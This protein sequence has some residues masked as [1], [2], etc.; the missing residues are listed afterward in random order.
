[1]IAGLILKITDGILMKNIHHASLIP[2]SR[3]QS[4]ARAQGCG[5]R[6]FCDRKRAVHGQDPPFPPPIV[7]TGSEKDG[8][9]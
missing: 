2:I 1:M 3:A 4:I 6:G 5:K 8:L 9:V 7:A